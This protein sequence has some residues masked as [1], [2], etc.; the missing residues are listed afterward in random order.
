V[1]ASFHPQK[2]Q[3]G[4]KCKGKTD[5]LSLLEL[6]HPFCPALR[7]W[8]SWFLSLVTRTE[9]HTIGC[10]H[11]QA[12]R[13]ALKPHH[14]LDVYFAV[15]KWS[16]LSYINSVVLDYS[17]VNR[18]IPKM[19]IIKL[20]E[21]LSEFAKITELKKYENKLHFYIQATNN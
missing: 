21:L 13:F 14:W 16:T 1:G 20:L 6:R 2:A 19:P 7:H 4:Q 12:L 15:A 5:F 17:G 11:S 3:V 8:S 10:P 9:P 18:E